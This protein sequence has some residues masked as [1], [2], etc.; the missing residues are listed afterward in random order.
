MLTVLI[1]LFMIGI[2]HIHRVYNGPFYYL[3]GPFPLFLVCVYLTFFLYTG[4]WFMYY[5]LANHFIEH[6]LQCLSTVCNVTFKIIY[7]RDVGLVNRLSTFLNCFKTFSHITTFYIF[8]INR[9]S[10]DLKSYTL[11]LWVLA[12]NLLGMGIIKT[13]TIKYIKKSHKNNFNIIFEFQRTS[14]PTNI[15]MYIIK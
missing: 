14:A 2:K 7:Y 6:I 10:A 9:Y 8:G 11:Y 13:N 12:G 1:L 4:A 15:Y 5:C 3:Q